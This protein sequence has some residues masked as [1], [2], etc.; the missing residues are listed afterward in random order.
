MKILRSKFFCGA[1]LAVATLSMASC[2]KELQDINKN[3]NNLENADPASLMAN[4]IVGETFNSASSAWSLGNSYSQ[5]VTNSNS[6]YNSSTRYLA[7]GNDTY[8]ADLYYSARDAQRLY[9]A[10]TNPV[11]KGVALTLRSW[12]FAQ[13]TELW[14][15]IPFKNAIK[16]DSAIFTA[17]YDDQET[18]YLDGTS[19]IIPSL[20]RA[21]SLFAL[22]SS[23]DAASTDFTSGDVLYSGKLNNWRA[24]ANAL[25]LRYLMRISSKF[26][27]AS[28][29]QD[30]VKAN[31]LM[32]S[33]DQD[34]ILTLPTTTPYNFPSKTARS[35]DFT[36]LFMNDLLYNQYKNSDDEGR[37]KAYFTANTTNNKASTFDFSYYGGMPIVIDATSDQINNASLFSENFS[38]Y[39][40]YAGG[41]T[42]NTKV[43]GAKYMTYAEQEFILAE[44]ALKGYISGSASTY[45]VN[46]L[47]AGYDELGIDGGSDFANNAKV[48]LSTNPTTAL[49][50]II[51]EK[52]VENINNGYE[53]WI[54]YRRTGFPVFSNGGAA[55]LNSQKI[56]YRFQYP[57]N[58]RTINAVNYQV[59]MAKMGGTDDTNIKGWWDK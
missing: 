46:G 47:Q 35:G 24:F 56:P 41:A 5:Y 21:D 16:G 57:D 53:G 43:L 17:S 1:A 12:A 50:Q 33:T 18:V 39:S 30:I 27:V 52:W 29:I 11:V 36:I 28:Q 3:P 37:I 7:E 34:A 32:S 45:Y 26:N 44:A 38:S 9:N 58:E 55:S 25:R 23:N 6:Y 31:Q 51:G 2:S 14:G 15:D 42:T 20:K 22:A 8:W 48:T 40:N 4:V 54:E 19:G 10:S 13:L 49:S 59:Q